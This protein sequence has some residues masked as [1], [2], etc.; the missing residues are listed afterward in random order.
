MAGQQKVIVGPNNP[1]EVTD[2]NRT[3]DE[4][5]V[6]AGGVINIKTTADVSIKTLKVD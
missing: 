2:N 4:V 6:Q 1:L 5:E 3:F